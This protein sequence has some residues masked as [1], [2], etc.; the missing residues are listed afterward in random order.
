M[1]QSCR[2]AFMIA[3]VVLAS[4]PLGETAEAPATEIEVFSLDLVPGRRPERYEFEVDVSPGT[5]IRGLVRDLGAAG[6]THPDC[7]PAR[8]QHRAARAAGVGGEV[9]CTVF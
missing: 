9:L 7:V 2:S 3:L 8:R 1:K 5:Y 6:V 4:A